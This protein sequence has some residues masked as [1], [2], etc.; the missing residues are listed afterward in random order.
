[1]FRVTTEMAKAF[2]T[3]SSHVQACP[4]V[5]VADLPKT[6]IPVKYFERL[7]HDQKIASCCRHPENH[8][9]EAK[10]SAPHVK[11]L[12]QPP[13]I[14]IFHCDVCKRRHIRFCVGGGEVRPFWE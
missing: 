2:A 1:M 7:E 4:R 14:Y 9:I 8:E 11:E 5:K 3:P 10:Y 12:K 6:L 13:D